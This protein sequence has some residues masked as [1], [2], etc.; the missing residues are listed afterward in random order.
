MDSDGKLNRTLDDI[1]EDYEGSD[2]WETQLSQKSGTVVQFKCLK[3]GQ[4]YFCVE[5]SD[6]FGEIC[7]PE[8]IQEKLR[9]ETVEK[10]M[11]HFAIA[12]SRH[13][14]KT[15]YGEECNEKLLKHSVPLADYDG[16]VRIILHKNVIVGAMVKACF[17]DS[18]LMF[19][20]PVCVHY[21][22]DNDGSGTNDREDYA[23]LLY[24]DEASKQD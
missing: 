10:Q 6:Q 19:G 24:Q 2:S 11:E 13:Y 12:E 14:Y 9:Q 15:A 16:L 1:M 4:H 20:R 22:S 18:A 7:L 17:G 21:T 8:D 3:N 5:Y 23:Y